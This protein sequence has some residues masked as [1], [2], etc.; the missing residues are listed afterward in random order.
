M[1][2]DIL[3]GEFTAFPD[4]FWP[5]GFWEPYLESG[6]INEEWIKRPVRGDDDA[7]SQWLGNE[8]LAVSAQARDCVLNAEHVEFYI[9]LYLYIS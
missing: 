4:D 7:V 9:Y 2:T 5:E 6:N 1:S 8:E 3:R